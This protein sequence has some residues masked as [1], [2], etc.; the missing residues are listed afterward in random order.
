MDLDL[1]ATHVRIVSDDATALIVQA[2]ADWRRDGRRLRI[3]DPSPCV[4]EQF[5]AATTPGA[6]EGRPA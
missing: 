6:G 3:V 1:V 2:F 5:L 4:L